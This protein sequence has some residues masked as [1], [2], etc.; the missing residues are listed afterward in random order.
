M[1]ETLSH[2]AMT[3][4]SKAAVDRFVRISSHAIQGSVITNAF[5]P[6]VR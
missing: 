3:D 2:S 6:E 5:L 4:D 1:A